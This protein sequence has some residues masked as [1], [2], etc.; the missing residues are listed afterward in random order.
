PLYAFKASTGYKLMKDYNRAYSTLKEAD[1]PAF[2]NRDQAYL[3][4]GDVCVELKKYDEA[5]MY[6]KKARE[7]N[8]KLGDAS[9]GSAAGKT[10]KLLEEGNAL[11]R[12]KRFAD[13]LTKFDE[14]KKESPTST[15][16]WYLAGSCR[17]ALSQYPAAQQ[18]LQQ[19]L[20]LQPENT[21]GLLLLSSALQKQGKHVEA[22][23]IIRGEIKKSPG[24]AELYNRL[25]S[26]HADQG[27]KKQAIEAYHRSLTLQPNYVPAR[28]NLAF[29]YLD[30]G[31][32][33]DA[34]R[35]FQNAL[36]QDP[37][38]ADLQKGKQLVGVYRA[39]D[40]GD[41]NFR[42]R[43]FDKA[44]AD[45]NTA[46]KIRT[47]LPVVTNSIGRAEFEKRA[48]PAA[49]A[50]FKKSLAL[51]PENTAAM[52]GLVKVYRAQGKKADADS[53]SAK[54]AAIAK[55]NPARAVELGRLKEEENPKEAE[56]YYSKLLK[57]RPDDTAVRT[58]LA[59]L[60]YKQ[61]VDA[62]KREQYDQARTL[63]KK[64]KDLAE[65]QG[66]DEALSIVEDNIAHAPLLPGLKRAE[67]LYN[68]G[69]FD[70]ALPLYEQVYSRW[71]KSLILV[72]I[73]SCKMELGRKEEAIRAL[74]DAAE[75]R[76][77][78]LELT[79]AVFTYYLT[80]GETDR[81][82]AGFEKILEQ[83]EEAYYS[84][85]K[86]GIIDLRAKSYKPAV[87]Y[88]NRSLIYRPDF[89]EAKI[90]RG[91][92]RYQS[93]ERDVA[94]ADF[95]EAMAQ[96]SELA[97]L[98]VGMM[99]FNDNMLD[100][101]QKIFEDLATKNPDYPEP[102]YHLA[103]IHYSR[104]DLDKAEKEILQ[105]RKERDDPADLA[106][107]A[108]ILEKKYEQ[109]RSPELANRIKEIHKTI[110]RKYPASANAKVSRERLAK[111]EGSS[112]PVLVPYGG[113]AKILTPVL[114]QNLV[115]TSENK[116]IQAYE[117]GSR[118]V[119]WR[120]F[121]DKPVTS[122][123]ASQAIFSL[124]GETIHILD[125]DNGSDLGT[126]RAEAGAKL[127]ADSDR[128]LAVGPK[129]SAS[130]YSLTDRIAVVAPEQVRFFLAGGVVYRLRGNNL[131]RLND[132]L[133]VE[134]S[135]AVKG[136]VITVAASGLLTLVLVPGEL[137]IYD[138]ALSKV[139]SI[140]VG[141]GVDHLS[142][143][144]TGFLAYSSTKV[145]QFDPDGDKKA[146][147][148][149]EAIQSAALLGDGR[150]VLVDGQEVRILDSAGKQVWSSVL[151]QEKIHS[152]FY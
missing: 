15:A 81:A 136:G 50:Q 74:N 36:A 139:K 41:K 67:D 3:Q 118:R 106:A 10:A 24:N 115:I 143:A 88:F 66:V 121:F 149:G 110:L 25:G 122:L 150:V 91:V 58:R 72:K 54:V 48:F 112:V 16:P 70:E 1:K 90:A 53:Y 148:N 52:V 45:Y 27:L 84:L 75:K 111:L 9:I 83:H 138:A 89:V 37:Q 124:E 144:S 113:T 11:F 55:S 127:L 123:A 32:Y 80:L 44:I 100:Q 140:P 49:E 43:K 117:S 119:V 131:E 68:R 39:L 85:Y 13:A 129:G 20:K 107:H 101:A 145:I 141:R 21:D 46:L 57:E 47:D 147:R 51:D 63:F 6:F 35:E 134:K 116:S 71:N 19:M 105:A 38:N 61:G 4:L 142:V 7:V 128:L 56:D 151:G 126:L 76:P 77:E 23:K 87:E 94:R 99:Q 22:E 130:L 86:L 17:Y 95:E 96:K 97:H 102:H 98:N 103:Y 5:E 120:R 108:K 73:A 30:D 69:R 114:Y 82:K 137:V 65:V 42:A 133:A 31:R 29:A 64:S 125:P 79:E 78:D 62:N 152:L 104:G 146:E 14:A 132:K 60:Y 93:G 109:S 12:Q 28:I 26:I 2:K 8:P 33:S 92:A 18:D 135:V 40:L 34:E 59:S